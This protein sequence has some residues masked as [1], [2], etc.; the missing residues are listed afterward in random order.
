MIKK[1]VRSYIRRYSDSGQ[2]TAYVEWIDVKG[3]SGRTEGDPRGTHM[4]ALMDRADRE[5]APF[6]Y[7]VW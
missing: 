6:H 1:F 2:T 7:E 4:R 5:G 3:Q